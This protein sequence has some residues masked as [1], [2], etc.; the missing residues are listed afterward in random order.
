MAEDYRPTASWQLLRERARL[1]SAL[2]RFFDQHGFLEVETPLL[3]ADSVVDRYIDPVPVTLWSHPRDP[4]SGRSMWLQT[5]PEFH[6]KRLLACQAQPIYQ[7]SR[8]FRGGE[9]G[10]LHNPEFTLVEWYRPHDTMREG[11]QLLSELTA[12]LLH[13]GP[14]VI[15]TYRQAF[16][17][18]VGA[19]PWTTSIPGFQLAAE[20][21]GLAVPLSMPRDDRDEWLN[22]LF[23]LL[24]QPRLG[25][26]H[27]EIIC[28]F[29]ATQAAL[30]RVRQE[31][32]PVAER[33]ELFL[34][35]IELAN[36]YHELLDAD[37]LQER[38][39]LA[40]CQRRADGKYTLPEENRLLPAMRAGLPPCTGVA[41]GFDRLVMVATG[42]KQI[43]DVIAF[44][45]DRA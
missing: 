37:V 15:R 45:V 35:G 17:V 6:M 21:R 43:T 16:R 13:C 10:P 7:V 28:D 31:E 18:A 5:S 29:P 27:P 34:Q 19:D 22:L 11:M 24:V 12:E 40:N 9:V 36:G 3:S 25:I 30:A 44:P 32:F 8:A 4:Q 38:A 20:A 23:G 1:L 14:A 39:R 42:A 26:T 41:L 2:R 33:F